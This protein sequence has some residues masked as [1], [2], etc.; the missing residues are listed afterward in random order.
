MA[1]NQ[2][3]LTKPAIAADLKTLDPAVLE[4]A[5]LVTDPYDFVFA[6]NTIRNNLQAA[7]LADAPVISSAGSF[8]LSK[9]SYGPSF[10]LLIDDLESA[11]FRR[12]VECKFDLDLSSFPTTISVRGTLSRTADGHIHTNL[13]EKLI[14]VL[15]YLNPGWR[16]SA[17][18]LRVLRSKNIHDYK[19]EIPAAFGNMLIFRRSERSWHG[20]LPYQGNRLS[21]QL[22]WMRPVRGTRWHWRRRFKFLKRFLPVQDRPSHAPRVLLCSAV[23]FHATGR[24]GNNVDK[25]VAISSDRISLFHAFPTCPSES[26]ARVR[27]A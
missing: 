8:P 15:L 2:N 20:H 9:L 16:N 10:R 23:A 19:L 25:A 13:K 6:E 7:L 4:A 26:T 12:I 3:E 5:M 1:T 27:L 17:G 11:E 21:V 24:P 14:T 22:N 18:S